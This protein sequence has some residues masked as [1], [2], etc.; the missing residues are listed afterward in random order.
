MKT[1]I[2]DTNRE[3]GFSR[4]TVDAPDERTAYILNAQTQFA[5]IDATTIKAYVIVV[6]R[7]CED[8]E[9]Y[10]T[11][12]SAAGTQ[13]DKLRMTDSLLEAMAQGAKE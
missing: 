6:L 5:A 7:E 13:M 2:F 3:E 11:T 1:N 4:A 9:G 12:V 8:G 10:Y